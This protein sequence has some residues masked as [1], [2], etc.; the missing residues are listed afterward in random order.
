MPGARGPDSTEGKFRLSRFTLVGDTLDLSSEVPLFENPAEWFHCCHYGGAMEWLRDGTLVMTVGDDTISSESGG[1]SPHDQ[2]PGQEY[3]NADKTSQNLADR[4]GKVLRIDIRDVDG[5]GSM[6]PKDNPFLD[7]PGADP[8]V[9]ALGFRSNYRLAVNPN[10]D[11]I[12]VSTVG[13]DGRTPSPTRGPA[14]HEEVE[15]VPPGGGTNHGWPRC[16]GNNIPYNEY[17][18]ATSQSGAAFDCSG[19][20]PAT[21]WYTY[22]PSPQT[23]VYLQMGAGSN[24]VMAGTFYDRPTT[25]ALRLPAT[26]DN[27]LLWMEFGRQQIWR[28]PVATD[29]T[30]DGNVA[31]LLPVMYRG[32]LGPIDSDIGP[33]GALY[34]VEYGGGTWNNT[35]GRISRLK[36]ANCTA[37]PADYCGTP[38]VNPTVKLGVAGVD[39]AGALGG[40]TTPWMAI[41]AI[42]VAIAGYVIRRRR[43]V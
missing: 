19:M 10:T 30:L 33:D 36:C 15:V 26:F 42:A 20:T 38:V 5:D 23:N 18:F 6:I 29:G 37:N 17:N 35:N 43:V 13:P 14:A 39:G 16:I 40:A 41:A 22:Q 3:N 27:Q 25:G 28:S 11:H 32:P 9:Y 7:A 8:Y 2:R 24:T 12:Y 4:R 34:L 31:N 21:I 1:W